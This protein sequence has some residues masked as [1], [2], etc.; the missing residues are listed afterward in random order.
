MNGGPPAPAG[1]GVA[2]PDTLV[3]PSQRRAAMRFSCAPASRARP[4]LRPAPVSTPCDG[5]GRHATGSLYDCVFVGPALP[6][7][8]F[9]SRPAGASPAPRVLSPHQ[10]FVTASRPTAGPAHLRPNQ[11]SARTPPLL[12]PECRT[13][14]AGYFSLG[15]GRGSR[16][17]QKSRG[18]AGRVAA[19][20]DQQWTDA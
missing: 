15:H 16:A 6:S 1:A 2:A 17:G 3:P 9:A 8:P 5:A 7:F 10:P 13:E 12:Q 14:R 4:L 18:V 20:V 19:C 11:E